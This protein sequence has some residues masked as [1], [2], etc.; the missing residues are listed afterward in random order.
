[1]RLHLCE[2]YRSTPYWPMERG[3]PRT[4]DEDFVVSAYHVEYLPPDLAQKVVL[5]SACLQNSFSSLLSEATRRQESMYGL[6]C[7]VS[8]HPNI[9]R[10]VC[11]PPLS[12]DLEVVLAA[13]WD[14]RHWPGGRPP[15]PAWQ[16]DLY[17][18]TDGLW[19]WIRFPEIALG[20]WSDVVC[21]TLTLVRSWQFPPDA[22]RSGCPGPSTAQSGRGLAARPDG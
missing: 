20:R 13:D 5:P 6:S 10:A 12:P 21:R 7:Y 4:G 8:T 17:S 11:A 22:G 14:K 1:M 9:H 3:R 18:K 15:N 16:L 19:I 2:A